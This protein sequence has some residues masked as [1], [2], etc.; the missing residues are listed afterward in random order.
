MIPTIVFLFNKNEIELLL[1]LNKSF[2]NKNN[3][4][5]GLYDYK[6][7]IIKEDGEYL[8]YGYVLDENNQNLVKQTFPTLR[9]ITFLVN[10]LENFPFESYLIISKFQCFKTGSLI[11]NNIIDNKTVQA[12]INHPENIIHIFITTENSNSNFLIN[13]FSNEKKIN[14]N[15]TPFDN[16]IRS[17]IRNKCIEYFQKSSDEK[18]VLKNDS[19]KANSGKFTVIFER[20]ETEKPSFNE[21]I[22]ILLSLSGNILIEKF[23][24]SRMNSVYH[25]IRVYYQKTDKAMNV[26][27]DLLYTFSE[28][29]ITSGR[30]SQIF[31]NY[32]NHESLRKS[33][34]EVC[35]Q[36]YNKLT[37]ILYE[38]DTTHENIFL[39]FDFLIRPDHTVYCIEVNSV[40]SLGVATEV[41]SNTSFNPVDDF[42]NYM[43]G[44]SYDYLLKDK[45][46]IIVGYG[47]YTKLKLFRYCKTN[48]IKI[49]LIDGSLNKN[50]VEYVDRDLFIQADLVDVKGYEK[51]VERIS[52]IL[53]E[54]QLEI[55][56]IVTIW[57]FFIPFKILLQEKLNLKHNYHTTYR[58]ALLNRDK[59]KTYQNLSKPKLDDLQGI[60]QAFGSKNYAS[61]CVE[62]DDNNIKTIEIDSPK[63]MKISTGAGATGATSI[64]N[65]QELI[66]SY[67]KIK[68]LL[69]VV[70]LDSPYGVNFEPKI[71]ISD[72]Y[73]GSEHDLDIIMC[74]GKCILGVF[75]DNET[76]DPLTEKKFSEK[77]C[78]MPSKI[79][80]T[81]E[82]QEF[83]TSLIAY[84]LC[85]LNLTHGVF[86]VE[87]IYTNLGMKI[88]DINPRPS[89]YYNNEWIH[90]LYGICTFKYEILLNSCLKN[91]II[92]NKTKDFFVGKSIY[93]E[94]EMND[95][96]YQFVLPL[97]QDM[98][99]DGEQMV[100][101]VYNLEHKY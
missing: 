23:V 30:S 67:N 38:Y 39:G 21:K 26:I 60:Q 78:V 13:S 54:K 85:K 97:A 69:R 10:T 91:I 11:H 88:I 47:S 86:N 41:I 80:K 6:E 57:E 73:K 65:N 8:S 18:I 61:N 45:T 94:K 22:E 43:I 14:G 44:R 15:V 37:P 58:E 56:S 3:I 32:L 81:K 93:H 46:I 19:P 31:I 63:I 87:F 76:F 55:F 49:I 59:L 70:P 12:L 71:F 5:F 28:N 100:A 98:K 79:I 50:V 77:G 29:G 7:I 95:H 51:E 89:G 25:R 99:G 66:D 53:Q 20:S 64:L 24:D 42:F 82:E 35:N 9:K 96:S 101:Q 83:L 17:N 27:S 84:H 2:S 4:L 92:K 52:K 33:I 40:D 75:S 48:S 16:N 1:S 36:Y 74:E 34:F 68:D 62:L 72:F 90:K